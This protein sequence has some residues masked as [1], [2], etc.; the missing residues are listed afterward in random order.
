[1]GRLGLPF[2]GHRDDSQYFQ[3]VGKYS[4][5]GVG[6]LIECLGYRVKDGDTELENHLKTCSKRKK[7]F[8]ILADEASDCSNQQQLSF[9]LRFVDKDYEIRE[10]FLGFLYCELGLSGKALAETIL[11]EIGNLTLDINNC[12]GQGY[13]GAASVSGHINGLSAH[14]LRINEK[15]VYTHCHSHRLNLVVAAS[16]SIQY[17]RNVLDQIKELSF[18]FNFL[19]HVKKC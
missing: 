11:T 16:C 4:S 7:N 15:A 13:D 5:G 18:F 14:I 12:P 9:V 8:S 3:N 1:M 2:R 6:N 10:E 17:V 19:S